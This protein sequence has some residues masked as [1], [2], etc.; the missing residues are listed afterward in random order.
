MIISKNKSIA[1]HYVRVRNDNRISFGGNQGWF[2]KT[3][4]RHSA[5]LARG[6]CGLVACADFILYHAARKNLQW[7]DLPASFL[8]DPAHAVTKEDYLAFLRRLNRFRYPILPFFGSF[9]WQVPLCLNLFFRQHHSDVRVHMLFKNSRKKR[10]EVIEQSIENGYPCIL[11]VGTRFLRTKK[12]PGV[13]FYTLQED[14]T[15]TPAY[16]DVTAHYVSITGLHFPADAS[17]PMFLEISSWGSRFYIDSEEL[18]HYIRRCSNPLFSS[19]FY[20]K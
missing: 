1:P 19:L 2:S 15:M 11:L 12:T 6:G 13:T 18:D 5:L 20:M 16:K 9:N 17:A 8:Q 10:K 4:S 3:E 14:G 7:P